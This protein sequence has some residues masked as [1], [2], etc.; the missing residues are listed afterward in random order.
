[1]L[2][3][4]PPEGVARALLRVDLL[5]LAVVGVGDVDRAVPV[6]DAEGV[7]QADVAGRA[8]LV[9]EVEQAVPLNA[10]QR[11]ALPLAVEMCRADGA[12]LAGGD[13]EV[14]AIAGEAARLSQPA[15][16]EFAI[17]NVFAAVAGVGADVPLLDVERPDLMMPRHGDEELV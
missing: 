10:N 13:V 14:A 15:D 4:V 11:L 5:D 12:G 1:A 8:V 6:G 9:A 7:L 16:V 17:D 3:L 2:L